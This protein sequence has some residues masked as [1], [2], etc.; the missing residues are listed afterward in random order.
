[1]SKIK[2][3]VFLKY[4]IEEKKDEFTYL[5]NQLIYKNSP[6]KDEEL[7]KFFEITEEW[8]ITHY[9][10]NADD[11]LGKSRLREIVAIRVIISYAMKQ[12]FEDSVTLERIG[13]FFKKNHSTIIYNIRKVEEELDYDYLLKKMF[14]S[15]HDY[16][17][18]KEIYCLAFRFNKLTQ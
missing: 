8:A 14:V 3:D 13:K 15:L 6:R 7:N 16:L 10:I 11:I 4:V 12:Y 1:M 2:L 9:N 18:K 5:F 17:C